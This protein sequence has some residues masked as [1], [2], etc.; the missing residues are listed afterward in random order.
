MTHLYKLLCSD[1]FDTV[2]GGRI[3][4]DHV[5][6]SLSPRNNYMQD[7]DIMLMGGYSIDATNYIPSG[8]STLMIETII[9]EE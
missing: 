1:A 3:G 7:I 4:R 5:I 9:R 2:T 6:D 8:F